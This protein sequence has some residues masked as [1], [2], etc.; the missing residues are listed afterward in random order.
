MAQ[1]TTAVPTPTPRTHPPSRNRVAIGVV[2]LIGSFMLNAM[3]RQV[4][5][6]LLPE[7]SADYGFSLSQ[8]GLLATGFTLGM[9][10]AALP[11][12]YLVDRLS[13]RGILM[14]SILLYSA[15]TMATP[16]AGG[17]GDMIAYRIASGFG[18]GMQATALFAAFGA[19]FFTHRALAAGLIAASFGVGVFLG[20]LFGTQIALAY[21]DWRAPFF[22]FG[23]AGV[24][25]VALIATLV[26]RQLTESTTGSA[27]RL[28]AAGFDHVP[29]SLWS[30]NTVTL[31][32]TSAVGG[33]VFYGFLGL[34]PT[35]L[36]S[37]LAF[38][39]GQAALAVSMVGVGA[40]M[41]L[42]AGWI[43]DRLDQ[44][45][46][47]IG[48]F[49]AISAVS[50]FVYHGPTH[51]TG[52]YVLAFLMGTFAAGFLYTNCSTA[53]QR[54][55]RPHLVGRGTGLFM[56]SYYLAAAGS[57]L[58]FARLVEAYGWAQ[59]GFLQFTVMPLVAVLA[60]LFVQ[61]SRF[62][63]ARLRRPVPQR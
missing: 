56:A 55:V 22:V 20:P 31:A 13:R 29:E 14:L 51:A 6:P 62:N 8:S 34:Y 32:I 42:P 21:G 7:I 1:T 40:I 23:L 10:V 3:D 28:S 50:W 19:Y 39:P 9:A 45:R 18:E 63:N 12:G 24:V 53:M 27:G 38:T 60:L 4:F 61:T 26:P 30:R 57:G 46:V 33:L 15:G 54:A 48:T 49:L 17:F 44:R 41:S 52:Q 36:R 35:F 58:I 59:A 11:A 47:L 25:V 2:V 5:Y 37:E 43:G 16:L